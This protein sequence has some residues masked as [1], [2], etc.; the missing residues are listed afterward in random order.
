VAASLTLPE[1]RILQKLG[2]RAHRTF[3]RVHGLRPYGPALEGT[4]VSGL[5]ALTGSRRG[6]RSRSPKPNALA[7]LVGLSGGEGLGLLLFRFFDLFFVTVV[8]LGHGSDWFRTTL[9]GESPFFSKGFKISSCKFPRG[10]S[11]LPAALLH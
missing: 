10:A 5:P 3:K 8:S 7:Y 2:H 1:H 4:N 11:K 6:S 9:K